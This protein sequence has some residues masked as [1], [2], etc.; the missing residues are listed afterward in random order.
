M[1]KDLFLWCDEKV[2]KKYLEMPGLSREYQA[3]LEGDLQYCVIDIETTG[4][5]PQR[6]R[7]IEV[8]VIKG[9][10]SS[11]I[12]TFK[13]LIN[14]GI[15]IPF[16]IELLTG[17]DEEMV[18]GQPA[19]DEIIDDLAD[20]LGDD[21]VIA[22][23]YFE[24]EFLGNLYPE[25]GRGKFT[26]PYLDVM[27]LALILLPS[28]RGH[29][30]IDLASIWEIDTGAVHRAFDDTRTLFSVFN[31][32]LN[33]LYNADLSLIRA[34]LDHSPGQGDGLAQLLKRV[35]DERS[36]G[37]KVDKLALERVVKKNVSL[38]GVSPLAGE[39]ADRPVRPEDVRS[40]FEP[41]GPIAGQFG[42]YEER[43]EQYEMAEVVRAALDDKKL[44][45]VEAG[46]GTGKSIAYLVPGVLWSKANDS[47]VVVSTR[48]LNLQDQ[49]CT[50]D[51]P[52][53]EEAM[54]EDSFRY[55]VLKGYGN[56]ICLRKLQDLVSGKRKLNER[57]IGIFGMLLNWIS[58]NEFGDVSLL[59]VSYLRGL[60]SLVLSDFR[61]CPGAK[62]KFARNG[63][64]FYRR[65]VERAK[66]SNV[67]VVNH[68]LL[69]GGIGIE[70]R[71]AVIDE[72]H[73]LEDVATEQFTREFAYRDV[74]S[75]LK[76]LYS[77]VNGN[78][79]IADLLDNVKSHISG[80]NYE[81]LKFR[82]EEAMEAV[83]LSLETTEEAFIALSS[84]YEGESP[85]RMDIRFGPG[86]IES[87]EYTRLQMKS[88]DVEKALDKLA[89]Q[90]SRVSGMLRE[91]GDDS[92][93]LE[94]LQSDLGGKAAR[95]AE[96]KDDLEVFLSIETGGAVKW[97]TVAGEES[98]ER[99]ALRVT[100][101][102]IGEHLQMCIYEDLDS[103]IMTSATLT[104]KNSFDFFRSRVGLG[105]G[106]PYQPENIILQSSFD[107]DR[108]MQIL[109]VHDMPDPSSK[110]Y[111]GKVAH[112]LKEIIP[113][114]G[115]GALVLFTNRKLM[116]NTYDEVAGELAGQGLKLLCQREGY[117]RRRLAEEFVEDENTSLF[118]TSSFW[119]GVDARG[120]TLKLV[121]VTRIP[122]ESPGRPVFEAR[123]ELIRQGG[124]S[125]F[126]ELGLPMA[127]LRLKQGV[128]R[129]IRTNRDRGQ[130]IILDSRINKRRYG[131]VLLRTLPRALRRNVSE[132]EVGRAIKEFFTDG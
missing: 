75:F 92:E 58:E 49:L 81:A 53:L 2:R 131:Q 73:T 3:R 117:S 16:H 13:K 23:S 12:D 109:V 80:D 132:E 35:L 31:I 122:F 102:D 46:T 20:F 65:A 21:L 60:D 39:R 54:G 15:P 50:K 106:S 97:A 61:E 89:V 114:A 82:A 115:G 95:I 7:I 11:T 74:N 118:G 8:A 108:Q 38:K 26:N 116:I 103:V 76:S 22:Y 129:L 101:V 85:G 84:F 127:A 47:P 111:S 56:Y 10:G 59:N 112:M 107:Y 64:C 57:Q 66:Y 110:E 33:G 1:A 94:Y 86:Q 28:I 77:P 93:R 130:V 126:A 71:S 32:L 62:C 41:G 51:L 67:V 123:G 45:L 104:V 72:A 25:Y 14:P 128:G 43:R 124:G 18:S 125:D 119:E 105:P 5:D 34:L 79:F 40:M 69:L 113:S 37:R 17:I 9:R 121:V 42:N 29:R 24:K 90:L 83:E 70:F 120:D 98:F 52:L 63:C 27:D 4:L 55:S 6:D 48:T 68:S 36:G 100:P 88:E 99:Q 87:V 78:G 96:M 19:M 30:Q 44:L 91:K